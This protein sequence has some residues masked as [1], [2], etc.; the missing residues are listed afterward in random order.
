MLSS[1]PYFPMAISHKVTE[2]EIHQKELMV[3]KAHTLFG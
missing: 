2:T 3:L 1:L